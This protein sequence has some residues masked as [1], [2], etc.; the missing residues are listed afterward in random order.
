MK[1]PAEDGLVIP[2]EITG[3]NNSVPDEITGRNTKGEIE[4]LSMKSPA[5][6]ARG[7]KKEGCSR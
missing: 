3:R 1:S 5:K 7:K 4:L 6:A 2:D